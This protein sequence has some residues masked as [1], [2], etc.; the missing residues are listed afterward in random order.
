MGMVKEDRARLKRFLSVPITKEEVMSDIRMN[1]RAGNRSGSLD[2][3]HHSA[4]HPP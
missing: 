2:L 4:P 3:L 1:A